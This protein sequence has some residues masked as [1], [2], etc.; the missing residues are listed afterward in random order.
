MKYGGKSLLFSLV[1]RGFKK[2]WIQN[3]MMKPASNIWVV[4]SQKIEIQYS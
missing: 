2:K 3:L 4:A 1:K